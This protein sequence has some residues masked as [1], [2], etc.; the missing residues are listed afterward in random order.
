PSDIET[1]VPPGHP[2]PDLQD[3]L[4]DCPHDGSHLTGSKT[5]RSPVDRG[6]NGSE[7]HLSTDATGIPLA[8]TLTGGNRNEVTQFIPLLKRSITNFVAAGLAGLT[9]VIKRKPKKI[10][11]RPELIDGCLAQTGLTIGSTMISQSDTTSST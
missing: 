2:S 3:P 5:G 7:H 9:R 6:R 4:S 11:Y 8:A 10:Q 1:S